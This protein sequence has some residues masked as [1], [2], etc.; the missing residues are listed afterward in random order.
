V[1]AADLVS[2]TDDPR[3]S[4]ADLLRR[5]LACLPRRARHGGRVALR[6]D[7][8]Y[9]ARQLARAAHDERISF[10]IGA[11]RIAPAGGAPRPREVFAADR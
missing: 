4:A 7:V 9:F 5:A 11:R 6:A 1:L 2:G 10:A 8:G 3:A